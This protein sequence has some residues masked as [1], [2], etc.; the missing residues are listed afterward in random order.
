MADKFFSTTKKGIIFLTVPGGNCLRFGLGIDRC[1][2]STAQAPSLLLVGRSA[3]L[4]SCVICTFK[5]ILQY[6]TCPLPAGEIYELKEELRSLDRPKRKEGVKKV[7]AAMTVGKDVSMLF[8]DVVNCMQTDDMELKKLVY[9]YLINYAKSQPDLT[10]MA[11]NTFVKVRPNRL[12][13]GGRA[14][15]PSTAQQKR[16]ESASFVLRK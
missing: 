11:V 13:R 9:L 12:P 8:P 1:A 4:G 6:C 5:F 3:T 7:I 14:C 15:R 16:T 10:I 2:S